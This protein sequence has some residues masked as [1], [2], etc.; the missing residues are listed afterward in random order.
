M[1]ARQMNDFDFEEKQLLSSLHHRHIQPLYLP[2]PNDYSNTS[3]HNQQHQYTDDLNQRQYTNKQYHRMGP[4]Y[5]NSDNTNTNDNNNNLATTVS[6]STEDDLLDNFELNFEGDQ[7]DIVDSINNSNITTDI[8]IEH[9]ETATV[10]SLRSSGMKM[11]ENFVITPELPRNIS[12]DTQQLS[13][14]AT[15]AKLKQQKQRK[16][17]PSRNSKAK[18]TKNDDNKPS[19]RVAIPKSEDILC[20]QSRVC[21]SHPGNRTFQRILGDYAH[22]YDIAT[23]KQE[24]MQMTKAIVLTIHDSGGRFLKFREDMWEEISTVAARDKVSHALRTKVS[25]WKRQHKQLLK[26]DSDPF[27]PPKRTSLSRQCRK[28]SIRDS[29]S[30]PVPFDE[31]QESSKFSD[32]LKSQQTNFAN[33]TTPE[34]RKSGHHVRHSYGGEFYQ[35]NHHHNNSYSHHR[36]HSRRSSSRSF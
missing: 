23:S 2:G 27:V 4:S 28:R 21:A 13:A 12:L 3:Y 20:G 1:I 8:D 17:S 15:I 11:E 35:S 31:R 33:M 9:T 14:A 29:S 18:D 25:S 5:T 30:S 32:L 34:E 10:V 19:A 16:P 24:K 7:A 22:T 26:N 36:H 6:M